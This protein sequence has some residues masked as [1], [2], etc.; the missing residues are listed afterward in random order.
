MKVQGSA[1]ASFFAKPDPKAAAILLHGPDPMRVARR[2]KQVALAL[3]GESAEREMRLTRIS[4]AE[5]RQ[6]PGALVDSIKEQGFFPGPRVVVLE[7]A[8]DGAAEAARACLDAWTPGD[9]VLVI[10]AGQLLARS[11]LRKLVEDSKAGRAIGIYA[12]PPTAAE[13]MEMLKRHEIP[14]LDREAEQALRQLSAAMDPGAFEQTLERLSLYKIGDSSPVSPE[15]ILAVGHASSPGLLD[16]MLDFVA[17]AR[18]ERIG[19]SMQGLL[20]Q[21]TNPVT[22]CMAA[23]RHFRRLHAIVSDSRGVKA[24]ISGAR[25]PVFGARRDRLLRQASRWS[26]GRLDAALG[27]LSETHLLMCRRE[28]TA[29]QRSALERCLLKLS[30]MTRQR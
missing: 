11:K 25:P 1:A 24:A 28:G 10:A 23:I 30:Y 19:P 18:L 2:R 14:S 12:D 8:G 22:I 27:Q 21:G 26:V 20:A 13:L 16:E 15:D 6:S 9:A 3:A 4:A 7:D 17:E 5:L 29:P